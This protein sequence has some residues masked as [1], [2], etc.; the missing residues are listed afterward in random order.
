M[1]DYNIAIEKYPED[2]SSYFGRGELKYAMV[3]YQ[4]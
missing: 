2:E 3:D 1:L 4:R